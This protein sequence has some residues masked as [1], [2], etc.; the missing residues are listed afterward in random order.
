M[1]E[2]WCRRGCVGCASW[3][4]TTSHFPGFSYQAFILA[5]MYLAPK[6][7]QRGR[8]FEE[9]RNRGWHGIGFVD[10]RIVGVSVFVEW[11]MIL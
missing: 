3:I 4:V 7:G 5:A 9:R 10:S 2:R 1:E 11:V 6:N 8:T